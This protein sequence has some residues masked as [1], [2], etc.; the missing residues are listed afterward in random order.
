MAHK[1]TGWSTRGRPFSPEEFKNSF[2]GT[3]LKGFNYGDYLVEFGSQ[4]KKPKLRKSL[5]KKWRKN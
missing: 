4:Y 3:S 2:L 5:L 1:L